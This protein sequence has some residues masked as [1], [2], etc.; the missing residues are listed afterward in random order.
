LKELGNKK[1]ELEW[2]ASIEA[3]EGTPE[4]G[5]RDFVRGVYETGFAGLKRLHRG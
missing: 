2:T 1:C 3:P 5:T 4:P